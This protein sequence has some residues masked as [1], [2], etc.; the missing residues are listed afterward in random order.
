MRNYTH[1]Q[2]V[3]I[4]G[5]RVQWRLQIDNEGA[6]SNLAI[7]RGNEWAEVTFRS[8]KLVAVS[9]PD[10][11][12]MRDRARVLDIASTVLA[13]PEVHAAIREGRGLE[14]LSGAEIGAID[15]EAIAKHLKNI[16]A[17]PPK[18]AGSA[19]AR[20]QP[21]NRDILDAGAILSPLG[22]DHYASHKPVPGRAIKTTLV[23]P[24]G[25]ALSENEIAAVKNGT[26]RPAQ[27]AAKEK[28]EAVP[29][30]PQMAMQPIPAENAAKAPQPPARPHL[31][32][33]DQMARSKKSHHAV[34]KTKVK[35]HTVTKR[36]FAKA[37][38]LA[39]QPDKLDKLSPRKRAQAKLE[40]ARLAKSYPKLA[41]QYAQEMDKKRAKAGKGKV[42]APLDLTAYRHDSSD[43]E[44]RVA[45]YLPQNDFVTPN[46]DPQ[47]YGR[48]V[49]QFFRNLFKT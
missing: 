16:K 35:P 43:R 10:K 49:S 3:T 36:Q 13:N 18:A 46:G 23:K 27:I 21:L 4:D 15:R 9:S 24:D 7:K 19:I 31:A 29:A 42:G 44:V 45:R 41:K 30:E 6:P 14:S 1:L 33:Y 17:T 28:N 8:H 40:A 47:I 5:Q 39:T 12:M 34:R 2:T 11:D 38:A 20:S 37:I 26:Y 25:S 32:S 22:R 48:D